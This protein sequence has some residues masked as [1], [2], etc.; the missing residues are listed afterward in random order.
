MDEESSAID[1]P[2]SA[3]ADQ[4]HEFASIVSRW[5]FVF[6]LSWKDRENERGEEGDGKPRNWKETM[7]TVP[8]RMLTKIL[9]SA[10][11]FSLPFRFWLFLAIYRRNWSLPSQILVDVPPLCSTLFHVPSAIW[12]MWLE[13]SKMGWKTSTICSTNSESSQ[14]SWK[15]VT[16]KVNMGPR[17]LIPRPIIRIIVNTTRQLHPPHPAALPK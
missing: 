9:V 7:E 8:Y 4:T 10:K 1:A 13:R 5:I 3:H 6:N 16:T 12:K 17:M 14:G 15:G 11:R 2:C